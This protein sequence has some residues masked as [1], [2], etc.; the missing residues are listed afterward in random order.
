[1]QLRQRNFGVTLISTEFDDEQALC[2]EAVYEHLFRKPHL[3]ALG[4][5]LAEAGSLHR[6]TL[7]DHFPTW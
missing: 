5:A 1:M 4:I 2:N 3:N 7:F 6:F